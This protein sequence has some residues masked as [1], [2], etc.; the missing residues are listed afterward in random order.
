M[1]NQDETTTI[2][3]LSYSIYVIFYFFFKSFEMKYLLNKI[4]PFEGAIF[5]NKKINLINVSTTI[6]PAHN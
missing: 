1:K 2:F 5:Y 6:N 4:A 3:L